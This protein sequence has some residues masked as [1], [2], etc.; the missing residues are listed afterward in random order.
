MHVLR[1]LADHG[2]PSTTQRYLHPELSAAMSQRE[3]VTG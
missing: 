3:R 1:K 2:S